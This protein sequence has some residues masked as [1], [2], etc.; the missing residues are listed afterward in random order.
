MLGGITARTV[1]SWVSRAS[2]MLPLPSSAM[3]LMCLLASSC[4][5]PRVVSAPPGEHLLTPARPVDRRLSITAYTTLDGR[6]HTWMGSV[7]PAGAESLLFVL[8]PEHEHGLERARSEERL[9]LATA[10]V[11]SVMGS[12]ALGSAAVIVVFGAI[13]GV[14]LLAGAMASYWR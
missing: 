12:S 7:E 10:D 4:S 14:L 8:P 9:T 3:V 5:A 2:A 11:A 6:H 1:L 13:A